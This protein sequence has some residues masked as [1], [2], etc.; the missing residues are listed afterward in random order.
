MSQQMDNFC[1]RVLLSVTLLFQRNIF[2]FLSINKQSCQSTTE[3][4]QARGLHLWLPLQAA[5][6]Q[7]GP[8]RLTH[9]QQGLEVAQVVRQGQW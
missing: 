1:V 6:T 9:T 7:M 4:A 3:Q 5:V 2:L 8:V